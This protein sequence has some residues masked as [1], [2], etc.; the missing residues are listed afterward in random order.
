LTG[1]GNGLRL[2]HGGGPFSK[3]KGLHAKGKGA[4]RYDDHFPAIGLKGGNVS[5]DPLENI[6]ISGKD[7]TAYLQDNTPRAINNFFS[8]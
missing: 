3:P 6:I 4:A 5:C 2:R 8:R 1:R 7:G